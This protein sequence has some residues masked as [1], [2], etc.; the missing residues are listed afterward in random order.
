MGMD[1]KTVFEDPF[2]KYRRAADQA[3][4][5]CIYAWET[6]IG[7]QAVDGLHTSDYLKETAIK[8]I[9][10]EITANEA[11]ALIENYY[12]GGSE[13]EKHRQE[14]ADKVSARIVAEILNREFDFSVL[15]YVSIHKRL[16][17]GVY[18]HAGKI[19]NYNI[20][21]KEWVLDGDTV[22]YGSASKLRSA[23][24][25]CISEEKKFKYKGLSETELI[26]HLSDFLARVWQVHIF[27]EG[28]TRTTAVF[29]IK[30]LK[31]LG[32]DVVNDVFA[33]NAWYFRNALVR[34]NYSDPKKGISATNE[35]IELFLRNLI[36]GES[37]DLRNR[38]AHIKHVL[39]ENFQK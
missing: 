24:E 6:A 14:E 29:L 39:K 21:K 9:E 3:T 30:H 25:E 8:N 7:L 2:K 15:E 12:K 13:P 17:E 20:T 18:N 32:Y 23:L 38:S 36:L 16:F 11:L 34:A 31:S 26:S 33:K 27:G 1:K 10:G 22:I 35:Y 37:N 19:R 5:E 28:N 4:R